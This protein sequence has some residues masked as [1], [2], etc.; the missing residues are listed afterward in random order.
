M[1]DLLQVSDALTT[2]S[3]LLMTAACLTAQATTSGM[4]GII[5]DDSLL[6]QIGDLLVRL[7]DLLMDHVF[8]LECIWL[9]DA[10]LIDHAV[11]LQL[12]WGWRLEVL[13]LRVGAFLHDL[14]LI[15]VPHQRLH[16]LLG[17]SVSN[18]RWL[19]L[20]SLYGEGDDAS[21]DLHGLRHVQVEV[22]GAFS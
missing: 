17:L 5:V 6:H 2:L 7:L 8:Q 14:F 15:T 22:D 21:P 16:L 20:V 10:V 19:R 4:W 12:G 13:R 9:L 11:G 18:L 3:I 1:T